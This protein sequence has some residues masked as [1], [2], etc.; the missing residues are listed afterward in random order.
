MFDCIN[1]SNEDFMDL[2]KLRVKN[3]C[4]L[5][6]LNYSYITKVLE[7]KHWWPLGANSKNVISG[8]L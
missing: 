6:Q 5:N 3:Y 8:V 7:Y 1:W 4:A 2:V